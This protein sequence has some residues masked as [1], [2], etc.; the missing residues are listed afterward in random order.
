MFILVPKALRINLTL[1]AQSEP[2]RFCES[3]KY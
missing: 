1:H 3:D 2:G